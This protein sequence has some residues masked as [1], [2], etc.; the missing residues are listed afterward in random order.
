LALCQACRS[1]D[2]ND[3]K[4]YPPPVLLG[5]KA[6]HEFKIAREHGTMMHPFGWIESLHIIDATVFKPDQRIT[7]ANVNVKLRDLFYS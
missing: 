3:G 1:V 5:W 4:D 2:T 6:A 7:F